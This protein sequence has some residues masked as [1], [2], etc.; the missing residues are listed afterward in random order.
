MWLNT[1]LLWGPEIRVRCSKCLFTESL[2]L[3]TYFSR[4]KLFVCIRDPWKFQSSL[5]ITERTIQESALHDADHRKEYPS[6]TRLLGESCIPRSAASLKE[7]QTG[8]VLQ[9]PSRDS[10]H[11]RMHLIRTSEGGSLCG[12]SVKA[13]SPFSFFP[14]LLF[15]LLL[16]L[17]RST[18]F[19]FHGLCRLITYCLTAESSTA[20]LSFSF[21]LS[22]PSGQSTN[23]EVSL[24]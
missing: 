18:S 10:L 13:S 8:V 7:E 15:F 20:C 14:M 17:L 4:N 5:I 16:P 3:R 24:R 1:L 11:L 12:E 9:H 6:E 22:F 2:N 23:N 21:L 19:T